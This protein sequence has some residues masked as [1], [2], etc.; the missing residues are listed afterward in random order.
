MKLNLTAT[1]QAIQD[2]RA[3]LKEADALV[4]RVQVALASLPIQNSLGPAVAALNQMNVRTIDAI[5]A[6]ATALDQAE[7]A[8]IDDGR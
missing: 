8:S 5:E 2:A 7:T 3:A 4:A 1:R 6:L